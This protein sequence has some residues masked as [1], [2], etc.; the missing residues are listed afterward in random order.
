V[1]DVV[2]AQTAPTLETAIA[3]RVSDSLLTPQP[4]EKAGFGLANDK[5]LRSDKGPGEVTS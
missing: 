4:I 3:G 5:L 1:S 2:S